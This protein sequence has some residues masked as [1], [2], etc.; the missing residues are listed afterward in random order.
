MVQTGGTAAPGFPITSCKL[1]QV[2]CTGRREG[3]H[4][5]LYQ[6]LGA[7]AFGRTRGTAG[8]WVWWDQA[9]PH[10]CQRRPCAP[11]HVAAVAPALLLCSPLVCICLR[12]PAPMRPLGVAR[13]H[14][15]PAP[16]PPRPPPL[17]QGNGEL[18]FNGVHQVQ[19]KGYA[20]VEFR[21][22]EEASNAMALDGVKFRDAYLK[23]GSCGGAADSCL[24]LVPAWWLSRRLQARA[25]QGG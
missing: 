20:F 10:V 25:P 24:G 22:V 2:G 13:A 7:M 18:L 19:D 9:F 5:A 14:M 6:P 12:P 4:E 11:A 3:Q 17:S 15:P 23:V 21:S 1:Y 16:R 8:R